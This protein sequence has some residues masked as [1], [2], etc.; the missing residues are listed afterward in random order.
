M[1]TAGAP[2]PDLETRRDGRLLALLSAVISASALWFCY[3]RG[4]LFLDGDAPA[5]INIARRVFDSRTP[6]LLQLGTVWLPLPHLLDI[7]F[8]ANDWLWRTGLG[9]SIPSMLAYIAGTLG[10]FRLVRGLASRAAAW[11]AGLIYALNPN[12][13]FI[14]STAM[15]ESLYLCL[16]VWATVF[17]AEFVRDAAS[18]EKPPGRSLE[19][20]GLVLA[21]AVLTRYDGWFLSTV[22]VAAL[23]LYAVIAPRFSGGLRR[24]AVKFAL[25]PFLTACLWLAYN[26]ASYG[27]ALEFANGPY[28][29]GAIQQRSRTPSM[30]TYPGEHFPRTAE[31][32]FLKAARL[33]L[34]E[35]RAEYL[36]SSAAF[37][38]LLSVIYFA[39]GFWPWIPLWCPVV[40][41]AV[42]IAWG[43]V[44][45]YVPG[46]WPF[47]YY[48]LRYGLQ[49]LPAVAVFVAV[50][51]ELL[52]KLVPRRMVALAAAVLIAVSYGSLWLHTP[53]CLREAQANGNARV[54]FEQQLAR[55]L[56]QLPPSATIMMD[57]GAH[58][59]A[60]EMAG[61]PFK[62][63]LRESNPGYWEIA[64]TQPA[65]SADYVVAID[66]DDVWG[67]TRLFP[68]NL[69]NVALITVRNY[70][71]VIYKST[72]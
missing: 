43:S 21:A 62:R 11:I 45:I 37:I 58:S 12:L 20:C 49:L 33:D 2:T 15:T 10:I 29:A 5:H 30:P 23:I 27:N 31:L 70:T 68:Q 32:Y 24:S 72:P 35:G 9:G 17:F 40:L 16:F 26:H 18:P 38:G 52:S 46:W 50:G 55:L 47:S 69:H 54:Q 1:S 28:S 53:P 67:A 51:Y 64:L 63:V 4:I 41:Y 66:G 48:N 57:C 6:G 13:I 8:I 19:K 7:P 25:L 61:I 60:V 56:D 65:K 59:G 3:R 34:G 14:Q 44:P 42:S 39:R 22:L 36:L 71:A